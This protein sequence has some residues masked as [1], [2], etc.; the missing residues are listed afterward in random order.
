[1]PASF[2]DQTARP[3]SPRHA[4]F[5]WG[6]LAL[7]AALACGNAVAQTSPSSD[8]DRA[9][10][11]KTEVENSSLD[12]TLF[13]QLL[14]GEMELRAGAPGSAFELILD[15]ARKEK[16][17]QLFKRATDIALQA[18]AGDQAVV[19][20]RA[21]RATVPDSL[22]A[23]R[24]LIQLL[25]ALNKPT[26]TA[27]PLKSLL[28]LTP[29]GE[30]TPLINSLP[31]FY[32]TAADRKAVPPLLEQVLE[33]YRSNPVTRI[34]VLQA[35]AG[36]WLA[37]EEPAKA[38][39]L[40]RQAQQL[41]PASDAPALLALQM[42]PGTPAAEEL[43]LAHLKARPDNSG[44]R[45]LYARVLSGAQR[46]VEAIAQL[47]TVTRTD[48]KRGSPWLTLGALQLELKQSKAATESLKQFLAVT[49]AD[50][51]AASTEPRDDDEPSTVEQARTQAWLM[52]AQSAEQQGDFKAAESWLS[53]VDNP[54]RLLDVQ[55]RRASLLARQGKVKEA[56]ALISQLP[57]RDAEAA[58]A[59][60]FA[61]AQL[62][63]EAK[64]WKDAFEVLGRG[65]DRF[66]NDTDLMYEQ[67]MLAE[68][69]NRLDEM[70]RLLRKVIELK[71]DHHHAYN[72]LG[73][74]L[75]ERK[76]RLPEAKQLIQKALTLA[77]GDPF[78]T[79]SLGWVEYR[80]GNT[81]EALRLL[82]EAYKS[83]P[84]TEIGAHLGEV[85]WVSGQTDEAR[86]IWREAR[87][88]DAANDVLRE[89][90]ARLRADL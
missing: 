59:K 13:Y 9:V 3:A 90:L 55:Q 87:G 70:E 15:A 79:D 5:G 77:P 76:V 61:E 71:P 27:E 33:P 8:L 56:R 72:A 83:R 51:S 4:R 82:R 49:E 10:A 62:L 54:Q 25:V 69:L 47:E 66:A 73:Y 11:A 39:D 67:S 44:L 85:L 6:G 88:R 52:L 46:Y 63:R 42:L 48:P 40:A 65:L 38:L 78:I 35:L 68:K 1:M 20:A 21:W 24:Y 22:D 37:A 14:I 17:E 41:E 31:R 43:V 16:D 28:Q 75:A 86:R 58:R 12:A 50:G 32:A 60:V 64:L 30:R 57:E 84:D 19:A 29:A 26:E 34:A 74:S 81:Q 89:T 80:L 2:P 36:S 18:R 23:H 7:A 45:M 53:K